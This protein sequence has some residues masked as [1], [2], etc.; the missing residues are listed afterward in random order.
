[1][2]IFSHPDGGSPD[3]LHG[4]G[5]EAGDSVGQC[6]VKHKVVDVSAASKNLKQFFMT[7]AIFY[8]LIFS[9]LCSEIENA[10]SVTATEVNSIDNTDMYIFVLSINVSLHASCLDFL[11]NVNPKLKVPTA[12]R[13][14]IEVQITTLHF[15]AICYDN[16]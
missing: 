14:K 2:S 7:L 16:M 6:Q 1:M 5:D 4:H 15:F 11:R 9:K 8:L 3:S 12:N 10:D 13:T